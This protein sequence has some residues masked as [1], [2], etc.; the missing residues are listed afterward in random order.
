MA[1]VEPNIFYQFMSF[2][3]SPSSTR[4]SITTGCRTL[5]ESQEPPQDPHDPGIIGLR[6][7]DLISLK[8]FVLSKGANEQGAVC[9]WYAYYVVTVDLNRGM[10]AAGTRTLRGWGGGVVS[11]VGPLNAVGQLAV[12]L[13]RAV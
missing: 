11:M 9:A 5:A 3:L 8:V 2:D 7:F 6:G 4:K 10:L 13:A 1:G 12:V